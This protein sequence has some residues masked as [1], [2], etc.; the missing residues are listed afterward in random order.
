MIIQSDEGV[1]RRYQKVIDVIKADES[2][3][4]IYLKARFCFYFVKNFHYDFVFM[5]LETSLPKFFG[6][7]SYFSTTAGYSHVGYAYNLDDKT[8]F[9]LLICRVYV[10]VFNFGLVALEADQMRTMKI[11]NL[12]IVLK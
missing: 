9:Q 11:S 4:K 5:N 8:R 7:G 3:G 10:G 12:E 6:Y 1:D 2:K